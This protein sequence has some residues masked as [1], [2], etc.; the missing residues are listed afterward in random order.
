MVSFNPATSAF[1]SLNTYVSAPNS[2]LLPEVKPNKSSLLP[3]SLMALYGQ[4]AISSS[5]VEK[6]DKALFVSLMTHALPGKLPI[7]VRADAW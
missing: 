4:V 3:N 2:P 7:R 5:L 6:T 1:S